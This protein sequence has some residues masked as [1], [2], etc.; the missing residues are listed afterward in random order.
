MLRN[1]SIIIL[2]FSCTSNQPKEG[3]KKQVDSLPV[4][5]EVKFLNDTT[6]TL[7]GKTETLEL[8][9]IVWGCACA[10]WITDADYERDSGIAEHCI[11]IEPA[12]DSLE[13]PLYF[14]A[15]R[16]T[17]KIS[18]QFY[19]R[20]DYPKGTIQGEEHLDKAKVF[21]YTTLEVKK[22]QIDYSTKD[23]TTLILDYGAIGCECA[24]WAE[25]K[26]NNHPDER[27]YIYLEKANDKLIDADKLYDGTN[28]PIE[29]KVTGQYITTVG[30]PTGYI[31]IK[32]NP[33]PGKV[34]RY[35]KIKVLQKGVFKYH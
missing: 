35:T 33:D 34:F 7:T 1:L 2:L 16:H 4:K 28:F 11:F 26:Y 24:Q 29:I 15:F 8:N 20:P 12:D 30:Y 3:L 9:Y 17:I 6:N 32:G 23:D 25:S 13:L 22:K 14:D 27:E 10:N 21:R 19:T 31:P 5:S 18:V